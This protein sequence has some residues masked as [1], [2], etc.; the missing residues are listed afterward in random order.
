MQFDSNLLANLSSCTEQTRLSS[1][2]EI[3]I[4]RWGRLCMDFSL[5][6]K[7]L[8]PV[9]RLKRAPPPPFASPDTAQKCDAASIKIPCVVIKSDC[10]F[11]CC[12]ITELTGQREDRR[13]GGW[14]YRCYRHR[15]SNGWLTAGWLQQRL[16]G[17]QRGLKCQGIWGIL[18]QV[19]W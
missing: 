8:Y 15:C 17:P 14:E 6:K 11:Q 12:F 2:H 9:P 5:P 16:T 10:F 13:I 3:Q 1:K 7:C 19:R 4:S 18:H